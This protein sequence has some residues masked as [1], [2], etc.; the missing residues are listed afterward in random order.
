M[1]PDWSNVVVE[2]TNLGLYDDLF[3]DENKGGAN[4]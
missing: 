1:T 4:A 2:E 3:S